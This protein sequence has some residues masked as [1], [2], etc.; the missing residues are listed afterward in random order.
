[1]KCLSLVGKSSRHE[2]LVEAQHTSLLTLYRELEAASLK[3]KPAAFNQA[4]RWY[5]VNTK[6]REEHGGNAPDIRAFAQDFKLALDQFRVR[7]FMH[8]DQELANC[9]FRGRS[10]KCAGA[11]HHQPNRGCLTS[12]RHRIELVVRSF[13]IHRVD[14]EI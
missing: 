7:L 4:L 11:L 14:T 6:R 3:M 5:S 9:L 8:F 13:T 1:M 2:N 12:S 10:G